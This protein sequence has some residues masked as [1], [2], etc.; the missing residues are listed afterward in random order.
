MQQVN[1]ELQQERQEIFLHILDD[2]INEN[3]EVDEDYQMT[4]EDAYITSILLDYFEEN[5]KF[6][7]IEESTL[8]AITGYDTN[9]KLY[10]ELQYALMDESI[11]TFVAGAAHGVRNAIS[12]IQRNRAISAK[13]VAKAEHDRQ[14]TNPGTKK[15]PI[16]KADVA[17][18]QHDKTNFDSGIVGNLKKGFSQGKIDKAR[19]KATKAKQVMDAAETK[20]KSLQAKHSN[21]VAKTGALAN[22]IDTG[23]SNVKNRVKQAISTGASRVG[24]ILGRAVGRI[25][26]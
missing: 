6:P 4:E 25:T 1:E 3:Y 9:T 17:Q 16:Y 8:E 23:I 22:K 7:T 11:G 15:K 12:A 26:S 21:N 19:E 10:E 2:F 14:L 5:Y 20:R 13:H 24:G 18:K